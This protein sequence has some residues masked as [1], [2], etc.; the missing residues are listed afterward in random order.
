ME[1]TIHFEPHH[2]CQQ[3]LGPGSQQTRLDVCRFTMT[4]RRESK[5]CQSQCQSK[6]RRLKKHRINAIKC[7]SNILFLISHAQKYIRN[8]FFNTKPHLVLKSSLVANNL[9][10]KLFLISFIL[11]YD[12]SY[13][14]RFQLS[15]VGFPPLGCE[16]CSCFPLPYWPQ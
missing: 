11:V 7:D 9:I 8:I 14:S 5:H 12:S 6:A 3:Y 2:L 1:I 15:P 16:V 13:S 4:K 10:I